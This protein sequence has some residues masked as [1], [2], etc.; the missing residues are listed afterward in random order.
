MNVQRI[1]KGIDSAP[2]DLREALKNPEGKRA[3]G[4]EAIGPDLAEEASHY[5]KTAD[6]ARKMIEDARSDLSSAK[7]SGNS[8]QVKKAQIN[9]AFAYGWLSH[10]ATDLNIHPKVNGAQTVGDTYRYNNKG[11][12]ITHG[13]KEG[14][15]TAYL[16]TLPG[17]NKVQYD[18]IV[19]YSFLSKHI[20]V[21][22]KTLTSAAVKLRG[23]AAAEL[24]TASK[25]K[26]TSQIRKDWQGVTRGS[27]QDTG[28]FVGN[29]GSMGNWDL[30]CGKMSTEEFEAL[31]KLALNANGGALPNDWGKKYWDWHLRTKD[32]P[33]KDRLAEMKKLVEPIGS[34]TGYWKLFSG[35][36]L[37]TSGEN[38]RHYGG[39]L[40]LNHDSQTA[41]LVLNAGTE[42]LSGVKITDT[43]VSFSRTIGGGS[44]VQR[45][46]GTT[47]D[48][49][50]IRGSFTHKNEQYRWW[51]ER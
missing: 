12:Q 18:P 9:L 31:R 16:R 45:Y 30:D 19:P 4:G 40:N 39:G 43:T 7:E 14:Q 6:L 22:E 49:K 48:G 29:P 17:M 15:L 3:F 8:T 46:K 32:L 50:N 34:L 21:S 51:A 24:W 13:A 47:K 42:A 28:A 26:M 1:E 20:G 10:C 5:G 38:V 36:R 37:A 27:V 44:I 35:G 33:E 2:P 25:V 11:Q 41:S 23:K